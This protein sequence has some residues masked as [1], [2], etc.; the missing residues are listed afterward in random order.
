MQVMSDRHVEAAFLQTD[1][2][3]VECMRIAIAGGTGLV[4]RYVVDSAQGSGHQVVVLSPSRGVDVRTGRALDAALDGVDVIVDVTNPGAADRD[5][6]MAFFSDVASRLQ[7]G[8]SARHVGRIVTLSITGIERA[9][10]N[11]YYAAKL[12][13]EEI[14]LGG[15]VPATVLRATQFHEFAVQMVRRT[16]RGGV[17]HVPNMRVRSVAA[18]TVAKVLVELVDGAPLGRAPDLGG[19]EESDL[20]TL[21][22]QF[23]QR[24]GPPVTVVAADAD[25]AVPYGATLPSRNA[26]LEGPT[27]GEWLETSDAARLAD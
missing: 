7:S 23:V 18:R 21:A 3:Q 2:T 12:R 27:F 1:Y 14:A 5:S 24:Y 19:P 8:G 15:P 26:R 10:E 9:A 6:P 16:R 25:S 20:V 22:R 4:G 13:Q 11:K 17:A